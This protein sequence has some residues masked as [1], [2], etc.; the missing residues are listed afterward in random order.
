MSPYSWHGNRSLSTHVHSSS[1]KQRSLMYSQECPVGCGKPFAIKKARYSGEGTSSIE[2]KIQWRKPDAIEN[3]TSS[4]ASQFDWRKPDAMENSTSS[5]AS[6]FHWRKPDAMENS[7]SSLASQFH[8]RKPVAMEKSTS[9]I[10]SQLQWRKPDAMENSTSSLASQF[11]WRKPVAMEK[12]TSSIA[13]QLQWRKPDAM[14]NALLQSNLE[15]VKPVQQR[16]SFVTEKAKSSLESSVGENQFQC[17]EK[18]SCY[19]ENN[20]V[21]E[22]NAIHLIEKARSND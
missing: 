5:I 18:A 2:S 7:T 16:L 15:W 13:S 10:A 9:S 14:E 19:R 1:R 6:Q 8:W 20:L 12:S 3:S 21:P 4:I 11:H 22:K 17:I